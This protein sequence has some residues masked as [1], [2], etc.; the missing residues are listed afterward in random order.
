M[1]LEYQILLAVA[2]DCLLGDPQW[3]PHPVRLIGRF[4]AWIENPLWRVCGNVYLA[5]GVAVV[6]VLLVTGGVTGGILWGAHSIHPF[7]GDG[8]SVFLLYL[9]FA[10]RD[11]ARHSGV[12]Q[13]ALES[14]DLT[15]ARRRVG[16]IVGRDTAEL[17]EG[18][19]ARAAVESV[20][21]NLVD[22]V[23]APLFFAVL[24]GPVGAMLY[25][26]VNT[27][28]SMFGYKNERYLQF[29]WASARLDDVANYIPARLTAPFV[30]LAA[31]LLGLRAG[32]A[33]RI[34]LRD[35]D[36]T[37]SPNSGLTEAAMAGAMGVQLGGPARYFGQVV[38]KPTLGDAETP[39]RREHIGVA[40]RLMFATAGLALLCFLVCRFCVAHWLR[41][42][43][44]W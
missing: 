14:G 38:M 26:A 1:R 25:K 42:G 17:D 30:T 19:V 13:D 6:L 22:G 32:G 2:L 39:L 24:G 11:L 15:E 20:A 29:G 27:L 31:A 36:N 4:A 35:H 8:A 21:E 16:R 44:A 41:G 37:P 34:L 7:L 12:V 10:A 18:G 43:E 28:D 3:F 33:W 9:T 5:G 23:T 40:N